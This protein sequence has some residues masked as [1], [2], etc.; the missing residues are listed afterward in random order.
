M[1][2]RKPRAR[3]LFL[4]LLVASVGTLLAGS[5]CML[6]PDVGGFDALP[7]SGKEP[8]EVQFTPV[9]GGSV[10]AWWWSFGD[11]EG[12][13]ERSPGHTYEQPGVYTV[14]LA[15]FPF[16]GEPITV[17]KEDLITVRPAGF[18]A[19]GDRLV[20]EDDT[21]NLYYTSYVVGQRSFDLDVL[22]NDYSTAASAELR[23]IGLREEGEELF[24]SGLW[25]REF[26]VELATEGDQIQ[27]RLYVDAGPTVSWPAFYYQVTDGVR[28]AE[29][30][31]ELRFSPPDPD[32]R[33]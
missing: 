14:V 16:C 26:S 13:V 1:N 19:P 12:S 4:A 25:Y 24:G 27:V 20:V 32:L 6:L 23:I 7:S 5:C 9:V 8:L 33:T 28:T 2:T 15:V 30:R 11:G 17:V 22:A 18:A 10:R 31:V 21:V 29:G 3:S